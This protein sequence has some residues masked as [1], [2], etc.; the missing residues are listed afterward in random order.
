MGKPDAGSH[1]THT[2]NVDKHPEDNSQPPPPTTTDKGP[3]SQ[4]RRVQLLLLTDLMVTNAAE[5]QRAS[6]LEQTGRQSLPG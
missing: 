4:T 3:P 6:R 5:A 2:D 1:R